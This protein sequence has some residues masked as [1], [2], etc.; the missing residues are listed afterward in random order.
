MAEEK[1]SLHI[2]TDWKKQAQEEKKRP[3]GGGFGAFG[4]TD[5]LGADFVL[6]THD[7]FHQRF[8]ARRAAGDIDIDG[9]DE[10][11]AFDDVVAVLEIWAAADESAVTE[12]K[13]AAV[14]ALD[15]VEH[16]DVDRIKPI[17]HRENFLP[18]D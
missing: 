15:A 6:E 13:Y 16:V 10:I 12:D 8:G 14:P 1:S 4:E 18:R 3:F 7:A 17:L 9:D 2:D 5:G 11:D